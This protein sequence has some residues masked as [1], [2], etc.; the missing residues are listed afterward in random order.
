MVKSKRP[1]LRDAG[2]IRADK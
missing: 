1:P 2:S